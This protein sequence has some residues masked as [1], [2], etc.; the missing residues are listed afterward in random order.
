LLIVDLKNTSIILRVPARYAAYTSD[1]TANRKS[2]IDSKMLFACV[3]IPDFAVEA[4]V[5]VEPELREQA[6]AVVEGKAPLLHVIAT[7]ER[8]RQLGVEVGMTQVQAQGY[9]ASLEL[10]RRSLLQEQA[11]HA[12]LMDCACAMSPRVHGQAPDTV[13]VDI[14]G[15]E[16]LFGP[17]AKIAR[18]LAR[19]AGELGMEVNVGVAA[20]VETAIHAARGFAGTT[21]IPRGREAERLA[22]LPVEILFDMREERAQERLDTLERWGVRTFR[23]LALLPEVALAQRLG[24]AGVR[25]RKLARGESSRPLVPVEAP[26]EFEEAVELEEAIEM[27]EPLMFVLNRMLDQLCTR[28]ATRSLA[29]QELRLRMELEQ[30]SA[31]SIQHS[32]NPHLRRHGDTETNFEFRQNPTFAIRKNTNPPQR[33]RDTEEIGGSGD[34]VIGGSEKIGSSEKLDHGFSRIDTDTTEETFCCG[35]TRMDANCKSKI[36]NQKSEIGNDDEPAQLEIR[37]SKFEIALKF[38]VPMRDTKVFLKLLQLELQ[39][40]PP[41][42]PVTKIWLRAEPA[43][44]R[45]TQGGLFVPEAP[46]PERL[47]VT[48]A[49]IAGVVQKGNSEFRISNSEEQQSAVSVQQSEKANPP[50]RHGGT[51]KDIGGSEKPNHGSGRIRTDTTEQTFRRGSTRMDADSQS[52]SGNQKSQID[53]RVTQPVDELRVGCVEV[54]D[55]H[56]PDAFRMKR[57]APGQHSASGIRQKPRPLQRH[58]DTEKIRSLQIGVSDDREIAGS[59]KPNHGFAR[60]R[61]DESKIKNQKSEVVGWLALRRFRPA[62]AARVWVENG[63]PV[64][65]QATDAGGEEHAGEIVWASGPWRESGE[66][67]NE[68]QWSRD[69]WDVAVAGEAVTVYGIYCERGEW[70]VEGSYD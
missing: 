33:H 39:A 54:L 13:L 1:V 26:L 15:L 57:F 12:A 21:V 38:P 53:N 30:H 36:G 45:A 11:A 47:E 34:R 7:N 52:E 19:R 28:L 10:R 62:L 44:P 66:W 27:L 4:I 31:I 2:K 42:A 49:R 29:A 59:E 63:R 46:E 8:A 58:R 25:L 41:Q 22:E 20:N 17:P 61:T 50:R 51:E 56:R 55:S 35:S 69:V 23:A 43:R 65:L 32:G 40:R 6:V 70:W 14:D 60:I 24:E 9:A 37:N 67:W 18:E 5:R 64:R 68:Q 16:R 3:Y 48:L